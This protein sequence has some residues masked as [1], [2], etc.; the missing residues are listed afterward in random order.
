MILKPST[1]YKNP[2]QIFTIPSSALYTR[3]MVEPLMVAGLKQHE[4]AIKLP[5]AGIP[6]MLQAVPGINNASTRPC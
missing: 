6:L 2:L 4:T 1:R 5:S 3:D